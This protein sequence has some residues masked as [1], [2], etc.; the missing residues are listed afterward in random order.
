MGIMRI[1][2]VSGFRIRL[3]DGRA[4]FAGRLKRAWRI[5]RD[6]LRGYTN[7]QPA[8]ESRPRKGCC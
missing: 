8:N 6:V 2:K 1:H 5:V 3:R 7:G 4:G